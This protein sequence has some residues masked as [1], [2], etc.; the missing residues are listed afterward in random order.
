MSLSPG[1]RRPLSEI[2]PGTAA[3][4]A[5]R[6]LKPAKVRQVRTARPADLPRSQRSVAEI[7]ASAAEIRA[8]AEESRREHEAQ[9]ARYRQ[10]HEAQIAKSCQDHE[11]WLREIDRQLDRMRA[12]GARQR[13]RYEHEHRMREFRWRMD[14]TVRRI[15]G[16]RV[17]LRT[18]RQEI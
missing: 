9:M 7:R 17:K 1:S 16:M 3:L 4:A 18:G 2:I 10:D 11:E 5:R 15:S 6:N 8:R 14:D 13:Q 12:D